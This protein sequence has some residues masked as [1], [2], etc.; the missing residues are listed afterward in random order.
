MIADW[1]SVDNLYLGVRR[2]EPHPST[3]PDP[4]ARTPSPPAAGGEGRG[5]EGLSPGALCVSSGVEGFSLKDSPPPLP[6]SHSGLAG[7]ARNQ[8][9]MP[10]APPSRTPRVS[11]VL[12]ATP[13]AAMAAPLLDTLR[14]KLDPAVPAMGIALPRVSRSVQFWPTATALSAPARLAD[15][16]AVPTTGLAAAQD[17]VDVPFLDTGH[18]A[19]ANPTRSVSKTGT[20]WVKTGATTRIAIR[21]PRSAR[22]ATP[23]AGARTAAGGATIAGARRALPKSSR[24]PRE[25]GSAATSFTTPLAGEGSSR[26]KEFPPRRPLLP[27]L[28]PRP[29]RSEKSRQIVRPPRRPRATVWT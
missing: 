25:R 12:Q 14:V 28:I 8:R 16:R 7:R 24:A 2:P 3:A 10:D 5:E 15:E 19:M 6:S 18:F 20:P 27:R 4:R 9:A 29:A 13:P 22:R 1:P 17:R 21:A 11:A 26:Q 23:V